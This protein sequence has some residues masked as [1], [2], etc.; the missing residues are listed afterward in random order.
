[1]NAAIPPT[2]PLPSHEAY[3]AS[4]IFEKGI[5]WVVVARFKS[6]GQRAEVGVFCIDTWCLGAKIAHL[7]D[8]TPEVYRSRILGHYAAD[9]PMVPLAPC[10]AR[11]LVEGAVKYAANLG[12]APHSDYKKAS[13][14]FGGIQPEACTEAFTYGK[15][16]KPFYMRGPSETEDRA[17]LIVAHLARRCGEG[18]FDYFVRLGTVAEINADLDP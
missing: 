13:R 12:F 9:F 7:D 4:D 15:D 6:G 11:K 5:G 14:V 16:G 1:M 2:N 8:T 3:Y 17:R 10:C 18:N